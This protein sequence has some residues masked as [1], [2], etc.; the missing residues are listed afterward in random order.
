MSQAPRADTE[1]MTTI[2]APLRRSPR[3]FRTASAPAPA[4]MRRALTQFRRITEGM[5]ADD[6]ATLCELTL[7]PH[8]THGSPR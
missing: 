7:R 5:N 4:R 8:A 2:T 6:R 3:A 1:Y